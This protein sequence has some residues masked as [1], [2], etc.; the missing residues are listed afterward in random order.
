VFVP[1]S[2]MKNKGIGKGWH[3]KYPEHALA[4]KGIRTKIK[5]P[6]GIK[7]GRKINP[8][9]KIYLKFYKQDDKLINQ[10]YKTTDENKARKLY[11]KR[12]KLFKQANK[13]VKE[14]Q[15]A[16]AQKEIDEKFKSA[17]FPESIT[18]LEKQ[19]EKLNKLKD[20][21]EEKKV[22]S[23]PNGLPVIKYK[24]KDY[25]VDFRL[26]QLRN[27][28]SAKPINFVDLKEG[29]DSKFKGELRGIRFRTY[30]NEY[31]AGVDD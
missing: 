20:S 7:T 25:F 4:A 6:K 18:I 14:Q 31:I 5:L 27:V 9:D 8:V 29:K 28:V 30:R 15:Y 22:E 16:Q 17:I 12:Q 23:V 10:A 2:A 21:N 19:Q 13:Q 1:Y 3:Y 11:A 24:G 26:G